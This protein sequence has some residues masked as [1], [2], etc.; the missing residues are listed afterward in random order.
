MGSCCEE[1]PSHEALAASPF[2][3]VLSLPFQVGTGHQPPE[4]PVKPQ[5]SIENGIHIHKGINLNFCNSDG[6]TSIFFAVECRPTDSFGLLIDKAGLLDWM[7]NEGRTSLSLAAEL[8]HLDHVRILVGSNA[9][10][11][12]A[13]SRGWTPVFWT[14]SDFF[15]RGPGAFS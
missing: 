7:D 4:M 5:R 9:D 12:L 6:R 3:N 8:G 13:D 15:A 10:I 14:A 1:H 11:N 2:A